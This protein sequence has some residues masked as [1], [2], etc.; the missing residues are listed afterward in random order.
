MHAVAGPE[1]MCF[2]RLHRDMT[3]LTACTP[4]VFAHAIIQRVA[5][6]IVGNDFFSRRIGFL[7]VVNEFV[8][9]VRVI[10]VVNGLD[11]IAQ[12]ARS[13]GCT[14]IPYILFLLGDVAAE[15][16]VIF[17]GCLL[18]RI[19]HLNQL[20]QC[21]VGVVS[22]QTIAGFTDDVA[23]I[24]VGIGEIH[25]I[26]TGSLSNRLHQRRGCT[27]TIAARIARHKG[28]GGFIVVLANGCNTL[29][30]STQLI[31]GL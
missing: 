28:I 31:V 8:L 9:P 26:F 22:N 17:P 21:I 6:G 24:I 10:A 12:R 25:C 20:T 13:T 18:M 1:A 14:G 11:G 30:D 27:S 29:L 19:I 7:T 2:T 4:G 16:V 5:D 3:Q 23:T 15:I